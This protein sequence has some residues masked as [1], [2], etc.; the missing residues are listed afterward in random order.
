MTT[1]LIIVCIAFCVGV[2]LAIV[3]HMGFG[4]T[5]DAAW[6]SRMRRHHARRGRHGNLPT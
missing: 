2:V 4:I 3:G 1:V 5:K 6:R